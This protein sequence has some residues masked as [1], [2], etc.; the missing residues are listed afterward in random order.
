MDCNIGVSPSLSILIATRNRQKYA[1]IAIES[2]LNIQDDDLELIIQDNSDTDDLKDCL[3]RYANDARLIYRYTP[4]PFSSIDNFNAAIELAKGCY[5]CLIGDDDGV[6][7]EIMD[8]ARWA[9]ENDLD[10]LRPEIA[11]NYFWPDA[12][13][14]IESKIN[15]LLNIHDFSG[16]FSIPDTEQE[17]RTLVENGCQQYYK[18]MLP[19][20]Y[21]GI[22]KRECL[23]DIKRRTNQYIKGLSP[24]IYAALAIGCAAKK[25]VAFDYPLTIAGAC[26]ESTTIDNRTGRHTGRLEDAPHLRARGNYEWTDIIPKFYSVQ[27]IWAESAAVALREMKRVDLYKKINLERLAALCLYVNPTFTLLII[28]DTLKG[29]VK[30]DK[31]RLRG[32]LQVIIELTYVISMNLKRKIMNRLKKRKFET[33][34]FSAYEVKDINEALKILVSHLNKRQISFHSISQ[35]M[36]FQ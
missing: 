14:V 20:L 26:K 5:V 32:V 1:R 15:G 16:R 8:A 25:V 21:H 28:R 34:S 36:K 12:E 22:V 2:I 9:K 10:A 3:A 18:T 19:K 6:N 27:T 23:E 13:N 29:M 30:R 24:D 4:P 11:V 33:T 35:N 7:P 17:M 31:S